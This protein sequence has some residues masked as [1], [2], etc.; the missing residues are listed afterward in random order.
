MLCVLLICTERPRPDVVPS[1]S[2]LSLPVAVMGEEKHF[3]LER[4]T[5]SH[6][7]LQIPI[8]PRASRGE[9]PCCKLRVL[10]LHAEQRDA[11]PCMGLQQLCVSDL[12]V[13][14]LLQTEQFCAILCKDRGFLSLFPMLLPAL[15]LMLRCAL[16]PPHQG[17]PAEGSSTA[18]LSVFPRAHTHPCSR[19]VHCC[20]HLATEGLC[21]MHCMHLCNRGAVWCALCAPCNRGAVCCTLHAPDSAGLTLCALHAP[22]SGM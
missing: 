5:Q 21:D 22:C 1:A 12:Q 3:L 9:P 11:G 17:L 16:G 15:H 10:G 7:A 13:L 20:M 18:A 14:L 4:E 8:L 19:D 6:P 2:L